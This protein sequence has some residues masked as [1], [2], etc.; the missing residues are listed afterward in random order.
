MIRSSSGPAKEAA[1]EALF[2]LAFDSDARSRRTMDPSG[3]VSLSALQ[4]SRSASARREAAEELLQRGASHSVTDKARRTPL[5]MA[6]LGG[7]EAVAKLLIDA[8]ASLDARDS[9]NLTA[10]HKA[11]TQSHEAMAQLLLQRGADVIAELSDGTT[12]VMLAAWKGQVALVDML[13]QHGAN[14]QAV[15]VDGQSVLHEAAAAGHEGVVQLLLSYG[16]DPSLRDKDGSTAAELATKGGHEAVANLIS[17]SHASMATQAAPAMPALAEYAQ[18]G[19]PRW[20]PAPA[21]DGERPMEHPETAS[22]P[23][24]PGFGDAVR[25]PELFGSAAA[26]APGQAGGN[27]PR[28]SSRRSRTESRGKDD[29][30]CES[31][32]SDDYEDAPRGVV[33]ARQRVHQDRSFEA[34]KEQ[35]AARLIA[36]EQDIDKQNGWGNEIAALKRQLEALQLQS[37]AGTSPPNQ[38]AFP[39]C[40]TYSYAEVYQATAGFSEANRLG[41][42]GL[43][44]VYRGSLAH[45]PV[46]VKILDPQGL[47]GAARF[48]AE[49]E[50]LSRMRHPHIL[51]LLGACPESGCLVYEL[52][53]NGSV[54]DALRGRRP[55]GSSCAV[56]L[57]WSTRTRIACE[58]ATALLFLH[59]ARPQV[60]HRNFKPANILLDRN[61]TSKLGD[62]GLARLAPDQVSGTGQ[63]IACPAFLDPECS[64]GRAYTPASDVYALGITLLQLLTGR[65]PEGIVGFVAAAAQRKMLQDVVDPCAGGWPLEDATAVAQ[66][67]LRCTQPQPQ[68]RPDLGEEVLAE[69]SRLAGRAEA[70][71]SR[72]PLSTAHARLDRSYSRAGSTSDAPPAMFLCPITQDIMADPCVAA[73]GYT[74]EREAIQQWF[75]AGHLTSPMTNLILPHAELTPNHALRSAALEW[76]EAH[77]KGLS[78]QKTT[79]IMQGSQR[80]SKLP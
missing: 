10:L 63:T 7:S 41:T 46:A 57:D 4:Q 40:Q 54:E 27:V 34:D 19:P 31:D 78:H 32:D 60:L 55:H 3:R 14:L 21:A 80:N 8:G 26:A 9:N 77:R 17:Q 69:L 1:A 62:V 67:A 33:G 71:S 13:V 25:Y 39:Q 42:G 68:D 51:L 66:L 58:M 12:P 30:A 6:A 28:L 2:N 37:A 50:V 18:G 49:V 74:Y 64:N 23:P 43:G 59:T 36:L 38:I 48:A 11:V 61:M 56:R 53:Q 15:N 52:M 35:L 16:M 20:P 44:I 47:E 29:G 73:D 45:T 24:L 65:E 70:I 22:A 79:S 76:Q 5:H 72:S 75:A